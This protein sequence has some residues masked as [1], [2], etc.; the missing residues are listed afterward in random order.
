[1]V[2]IDILPNEIWLNVFEH[3]DLKTMS[4]LLC[5]NKYF[6]DIITPMKW[7]IIDSMHNKGYP[8]PKNEPTYL[9]YIYC[10]DWTTY[11]FNKMTIPEDV[12]INLHEYIDFAVVTS[13][14]KFSEQ[15]IRKF[16]HKIPM[17]NLLIHQDVPLDILTPLIDSHIVNYFHQP[18][19][20]YVWSNQKISVDFINKFKQYVDWNAISSNKNALSFDIINE[21][22]NELIWPEVT[23]HGIH[24]SILE[25]FIYKMD[26]FSWKNV[27][28]FSKLSE[29][30][31]LKYID[32]LEIISLFGSQDMSESLI[33]YLMSKLIDEDEINDA[34]GKISMHQ[35]LSYDFINTYKMVLKLI[36]MIRNPK[37]KRKYLKMVYN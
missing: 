10:I 18:Y 28:Y 8:I 36:Y 34:W 19:W 25:H 23:S 29:N 33:L 26:L 15:L 11:I 17:I 1:M 7:D 6:N 16:Y 37:I 24:E 13:K 14:Q 5:T 35:C 32:H 27:G 3:T 31:I 22:H 9:E 12:I 30:F 20:Y 4:S 2:N 21:F